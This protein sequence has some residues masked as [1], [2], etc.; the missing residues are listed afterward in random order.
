MDITEP[1]TAFRMAIP[2]AQLDDLHDR[3][4]RTRFPAPLPGDGWDT[5]VPVSYLKELVTYWDRAYDW[6]AAETEL[7]QLPQFTTEIH[8]TTI[9]FL[10]LRSPE[11]DARQR[12]HRHAG[13]RAQQ[14]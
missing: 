3:L 10:H 8:G 7:N 11:L 14:G 9:H 13:R 5:G 4:R 1:I 6:R 2:D 12:E